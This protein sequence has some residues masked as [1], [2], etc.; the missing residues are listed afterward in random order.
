MANLSKEKKAEEAPAKKKNEE[1]RPPE[2]A[3]EKAK[4]L[5]KEQRRQL[6]VRWKADFDLVQVRTFS[7][8]PSEMSGNARNVRDVGNGKEKE[9][10]TL[11]K[12][13]DMMDVDEEDDGLPMEQTY[14]EYRDPSVIDF[15]SSSRRRASP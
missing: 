5:R 7:P 10:F 6:R 14:F 13:M 9:G 11:K 8:D 12:H 2:T 15:S 1:N 3:E 4:R